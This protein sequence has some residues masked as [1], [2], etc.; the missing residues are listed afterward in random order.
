MNWLAQALLQ[1]HLFCHKQMILAAK[2]LGQIE[3]IIV[4]FFH[5]LESGRHVLNF[6][7]TQRWHVAHV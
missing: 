4:Y 5:L 1:K 2:K 3:G 6:I 7:E